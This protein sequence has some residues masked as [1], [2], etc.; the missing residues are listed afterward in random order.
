MLTSTS[1][2]LKSSSIAKISKAEGQRINK[3][4]V[5]RWRCQ[6]GNDGGRGRSSRD[7]L[8][9]GLT[10]LAL[11]AYDIGQDVALLGR[12]RPGDGDWGGGLGVAAQT[13][14]WYSVRRRGCSKV[15]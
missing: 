9:T 13:R 10:I 4:D 6:V 15:R 11:P 2:H 5:V 1:R 14:G 7:R 3:Y 12:R 8:R